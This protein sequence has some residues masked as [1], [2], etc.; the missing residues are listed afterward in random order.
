MSEQ[1]VVAITTTNHLL[2]IALAADVLAHIDAESANV[3]AAQ[4]PTWNFYAATGRALVRRDDPATGT[5]RLVPDPAEN[6]PTVKEK[7]LLVDRIDAF[8]A[9][10]QVELSTD[11]LSGAQLKHR[12]TPRAVGDLPDVVTALAAVM[13]LPDGPSQPDSR[14][15]LHNLGHRIFG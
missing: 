6:A 1:P 9:A 15:W 11:L 13:V 8:L 5:S 10:A 4:L 7:Q 2:H 14:D 12:R 3:P